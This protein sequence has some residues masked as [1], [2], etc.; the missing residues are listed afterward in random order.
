MDSAPMSEAEMKIGAVE[1]GQRAG[2]RWAQRHATACQIA[3]L[4]ANRQPLDD[5]FRK[6]TTRDPQ[7][8]LS[9]I[10][11]FAID[12]AAPRTKETAAQFWQS[13][14]WMTSRLLDNPLFIGHFVVGVVMVANTEAHRRN[15][16]SN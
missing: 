14:P 15:A 13:M 1:A 12:P 2:A 9:D 11:A 3:A 4:L 16:T 8:T 5:W 6:P 10:V 7:F